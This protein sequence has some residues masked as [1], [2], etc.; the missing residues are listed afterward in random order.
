MDL[1]TLKN[2]NDKTKLVFF[3]DVYPPYQGSKVKVRMRVGCLIQVDLE[4]SD[5]LINKMTTSENTLKSIYRNSFSNELWKLTVTITL[6]EM[7]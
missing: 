6:W 2:S 3:N 5:I 7:R 4:S 1:K